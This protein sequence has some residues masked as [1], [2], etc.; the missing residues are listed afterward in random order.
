MAR[1]CDRA[2][3]ARANLTHLS[4]QI[5]AKSN[6]RFP[7]MPPASDRSAIGQTQSLKLP[8]KPAFNPEQGT[9]RL[10]RTWF[11]G[12]IGGQ[13]PPPHDPN[14]NGSWREQSEIARRFTWLITI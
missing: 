8:S 7:P 5:P 10:T 4:Q 2:A 9:V 1:L 11:V 3:T 13:F 12:R 6:G 14:G